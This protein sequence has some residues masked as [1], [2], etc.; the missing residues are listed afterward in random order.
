[1][2]QKASFIRDLNISVHMKAAQARPRSPQPGRAAEARRAELR[3]LGRAPLY[4][5]CAELQSEFCPRAAKRGTSARYC[6]S[7]KLTVTL[8]CKVVSP[9]AIGGGAAAA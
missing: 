5:D 7:S 2:Q 8:I 9:G 4:P 3:R 1:G 6:S